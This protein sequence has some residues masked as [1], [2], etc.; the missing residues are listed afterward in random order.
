MTKYQPWYFQGPDPVLYSEY[1]T[2]I[3]GNYEYNIKLVGSITFR[4]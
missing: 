2:S 4:Y 3:P 1:N